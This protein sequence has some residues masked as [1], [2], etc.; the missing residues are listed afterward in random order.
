MKN[1]KDY[2]RQIKELRHKY[3]ESIVEIS[4]RDNK[5]AILNTQINELQL[6]LWYNDRASMLMRK[7]FNKVDDKIIRGL[8]ERGKKKQPVRHKHPEISLNGDESYDDL[9]NIVKICDIKDF[10]V[11]RRRISNSPLKFHYRITAKAYRLIRDG[12]MHV[13]S[14]VHKAIK[15][16]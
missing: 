2:D 6:Q 8:T 14:K 4:K 7:L 1:S 13:A 16:V 3:S 12:S 5:I 15:K 11:Y 9:L 10:F